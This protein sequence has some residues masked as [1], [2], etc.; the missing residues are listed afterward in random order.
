MDKENSKPHTSN[1]FGRRMHPCGIEGCA[2][3]TRIGRL[4]GHRRTHTKVAAKPLLTPKLQN[5]NK[6]TEQREVHRAAL[7][8]QKNTYESQAQQLRQQMTTQQEEHNEELAKVQKDAQLQIDKH[9]ETVVEKQT[10]IDKLNQELSRVKKDQS[11]D[12]SRINSLEA[13]L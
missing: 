1:K 8:N 2:Y 9:Q 10:L 4:D 3:T 7:T 6:K 11:A 12:K 13:D 5:A